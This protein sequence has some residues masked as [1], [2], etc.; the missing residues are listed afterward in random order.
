MIVLL[1]N[2]AALLQDEA[3]IITKRGRYYKTGQGLL[4]NEG[5]IEKQD[6]YYKTGPTSPYGLTI[7]LMKEP[8]TNKNLPFVPYIFIGPCFI[9]LVV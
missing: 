1:Q 5:G 7:S 8:N 3:G 9:E 4:K 6:N 2:R